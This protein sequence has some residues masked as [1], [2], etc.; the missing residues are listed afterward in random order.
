MV[1]RRDFFVFIDRGGKL[2]KYAV[3]RYLEERLKNHYT[4]M[5][6]ARN[7]IPAVLKKLV[8]GEV[9]KRSR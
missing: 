8:D 2:E 6:P 4:V 9:R 5:S 7:D 3:V 1:G